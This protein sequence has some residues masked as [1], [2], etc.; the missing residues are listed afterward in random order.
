MSR[1][2]IS[3][4]NFTLDTKVRKAGKES[5]LPR[6][7]SAKKQHCHLAILSDFSGRDQRGFNDIGS[8]RNR[9]IIEID[10]D[11]FDEVFESLD[12]QCSL[13]L[14]DEPMCFKELDDMHPDFIYEQVPLFNA[15]KQLKRKLKGKS[16]FAEAAAEIQT[17]SE[18][19]SNSTE[20]KYQADELSDQGGASSLPSGSILDNILAGSADLPTQSSGQFDLQA[21]VKDIVGPYITDKPDPQQ[22]ELMANVDEASSSLMRKVMHHPQ[23]QQLESAWRSLY[24]LVKRLETDQNLK[25]FIVDI[26]AQEIID[27][28]NQAESFEQSGV[29]KVL[30]ES[31]ATAGRKAFNLVMVDAT[32]GKNTDGLSA[33]S[34]LGETVSAMNASLI[35]GGSEQLAGCESLGLTPDKDDWDFTLN[36]EL[37]D[38]WQQLRK[39]P[40]AKSIALV[41][42]RYLTRMPYG[43]KTSP[44]DSFAYEELP[45]E[46]KHPYYLWSCGAWLVS[47]LIA[48]NYAI[49]G[50]LNIQQLQEIEKLPLH[51]FEGEDGSCVTPCA[52]I[53]MYDSAAIA[54]R[55]AGLMTVRSILN[56]DSVIVPELVSISSLS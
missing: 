21:L 8:I 13:Q 10:R 16:T 25:L 3:T 50:E 52:E 11:N 54:L 12:V 34:Q 46:G 22:K 28:A 45:Q 55:G 26:S 2:T 31:R 44:I 1:A 32:F 51:V 43:K 36:L 7:L 37:S 33:L 20:S 18:R 17:W 5:G 6:D 40:Q 42:P 38:Q 41:A 39:T 24:L 15:F 35:S 23:F 4:G 49:S 48:K 56:K 27:D 47:L 14:A 9:K 29:Y 19:G 53:N 30:H